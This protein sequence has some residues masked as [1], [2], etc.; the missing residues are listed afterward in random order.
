MRSD[1]DA[2]WERR[3]LGY[4]V[5]VAVGVATHLFMVLV[6]LGQGTLVAAGGLRSRAWLTRWTAGVL[7]GGVAYV[8][9]ARVML[10]RA[11]G[12]RVF[13]SGL[14][15]QLP[16]LFLGN[17]LVAEILIGIVVAVGV[18]PFLVRR[19]GR[20]L[21]VAYCSAFLLIWLVIQPEFLYGR[22]FVWAVPAVACAIAS[23]V[24]RHRALMLLVVAATIIQVAAQMPHRHDDQAP[25]RL[26]ARVVEIASRTGTP[27]CVDAETGPVLLIETRSFTTVRTADA[28]SAC[29]V[30]LTLVPGARIPL[31]AAARAQFPVAT[32][33]PASSRGLVLSRRPIG[34]ETQRIG[35]R[36]EV[37]RC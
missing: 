22:F 32:E 6:L 2:F 33:L 20:V 5:A 31:L 15:G 29:D 4:V 8:G 25:I 16:A 7:V 18:A 11:G 10:L 19:E 27:A 23:A 12:G 9:V 14:P 17:P 13:R 24:S 34:C 1:G 36:V 28:L 21:A 26:A 30:F 37:V 3:S 35:D